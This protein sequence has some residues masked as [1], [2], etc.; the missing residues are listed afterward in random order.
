MDSNPMNPS[1]VTSGLDLHTIATIVAQVNAIQAVSLRSSVNPI[2]DPSSPFFLHP[3]EYPGNSL[4]LLVLDTT[5]YGS[6]SR[7]MQRALKSKN[8]LG[9]VDGSLPKPTE[10]DLVFHAWDKCNNLVVFWITRSLSPE[11][12]NSV[13]WNG[14]AS[15]IWDKLKKRFYHGDVF[16]IA[17]LDEE[18]FSTRQGDLTV[19]SYFMKLKGI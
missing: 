8:K 16:R 18:L 4:I 1:S 6:W 19:T 10:D 2:M 12:A 5:K 14:V 15:D 7:S 13:L 9:F 11:I 3:G 17:E